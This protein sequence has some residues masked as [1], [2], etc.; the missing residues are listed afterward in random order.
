MISIDMQLASGYA[1]SHEMTQGSAYIN[2]EGLVLKEYLSGQEHRSLRTKRAIFNQKDN[3]VELIEPNFF[4]FNS[5]GKP[6]LS[7]TAASSQVDLKNQLIQI[8]GNVHV[9]L[10]DQTDFYTTQLF[11]N[12][13]EKTFYTNAA[14]KLIRDNHQIDGKGLIADEAFENIQIQQ[15]AAKRTLSV[16]ATH[17]TKPNQAIQSKK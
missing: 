5:Q 15:F 14:I 13:R 11:W 2:T 17:T 8:Q 6:M 1:I 4:L 16:P 7:L 3:I 10:T 12:T 9:R